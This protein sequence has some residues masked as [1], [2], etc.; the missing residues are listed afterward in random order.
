[1][2]EPLN[3]LNDDGG[4]IGGCPCCGAPLRPAKDAVRTGHWH[5]AGQGPG[6]MLF[7][8]CPQCH[9]RLIGSVTPGDRWEDADTA[10]VAWYPGS[11]RDPKWWGA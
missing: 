7:F 2:P 4:R 3:D 11:H 10:Q 1:M 5:V 6:T 8:V 9:E